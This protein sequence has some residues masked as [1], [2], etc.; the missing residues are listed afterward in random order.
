M[1]A[2]GYIIET[3]V[4]YC[5]ALLTVCATSLQ[6]FYAWRQP[7][8]ENKVQILHKITLCPLLVNAILALILSVDL[9][10]VYHIYPIDFTG[11]ITVLLTYQLVISGLVWYKEI[12]DLV[13]ATNKVREIERLLRYL[14]IS[15]LHIGVLTGLHVVITIALMMISV[16]IRYIGYFAIVA[17]YLML[18]VFFVA[19]SCSYFCWIIWKQYKSIH[20][21]NKILSQGLNPSAS[22]ELVIKEGEEVD[23]KYLQEISH[24]PI[25]PQKFKLSQKFSH[26]PDSMKF[27]DRTSSSSNIT[28]AIPGIVIIGK[29]DKIERY[30]RIAKVTFAVGF[31]C[32]LM[33]IGLITAII[34]L[35]TRNQTIDSELSA[36]P[37]VYS[38][39]RD[40]FCI[41]GALAILAALGI[42]VMWLPLKA[43]VVV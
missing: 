31:V 34:N 41:F 2:V 9:R 13:F 35:L 14:K 1:V 6:I 33:V 11:S 5:T 27:I 19:M 18:I 15:Y 20:S 23:P 39:N 25:S 4:F 32:G 36:D 29:N 3:I 37:N 38:F 8:N 7:H 28:S 40:I 21:P 24:P 17:G 12:A 16:K 22:L 30:L 26:D 42:S 10:G 43:H